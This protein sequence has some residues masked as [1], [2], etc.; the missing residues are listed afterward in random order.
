M[1]DIENELASLEKELQ[2]ESKK[3]ELARRRVEL[4]KV[5]SQTEQL[6]NLKPT[7]TGEIN[8]NFE[9]KVP[10]TV[11]TVSESI[12][13]TMEQ[14]EII[15]LKAKLEVLSRTSVQQFVVLVKD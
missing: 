3:L 12:S 2:L 11:K 9:T 10:T 4:E 8:E 7:V 6:N 5:K 14:L 13:I 15:Q 1:N